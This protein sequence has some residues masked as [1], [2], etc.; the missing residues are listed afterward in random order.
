MY[1]TYLKQDGA[2]LAELLPP[3]PICSPGLT[4][5]NAVLNPAQTEYLYFRSCDNLRHV[6]TTSLAEHSAI[7]CP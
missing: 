7:T 4:A 6:F 3:G 2:P 5:I 1:N